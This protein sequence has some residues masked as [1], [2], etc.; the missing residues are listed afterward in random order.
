MGRH[1][2]L[3]NAG[4]L[5]EA[6]GYDEEPELDSRRA[7]HIVEA[8]ARH[9]AASNERIASILSQKRPQEDFQW[10]IHYRTEYAV[11]LAGRARLEC[12]IPS[13]L[14]KLDED[15]GD[16]LNQECQESLARIGSPAV[17]RAIDERFAGITSEVRPYIADARGPFIRTSLP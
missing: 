14:D 5:C 9:G 17:V 11:R 1:E 8:L 13:L 15:W 10:P 6:A 7:G 12:F 3:A 2:L 4:A 16:F